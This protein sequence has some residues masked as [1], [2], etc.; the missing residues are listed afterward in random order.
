MI[1]RPL[2][3][4]HGFLSMPPWDLLTVCSGSAS[5]VGVSVSWSFFVITNLN[6]FHLS[7]KYDFALK[8]LGGGKKTNKRKPKPIELA[9]SGT[10]V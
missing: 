2:A 7:C 5:A 9:N 10:E 8:K 3:N 6:L 4:R 1:A